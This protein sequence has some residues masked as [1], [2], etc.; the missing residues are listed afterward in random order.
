[1]RKHRLKECSVVVNLA[2]QRF[3]RLKYTGSSD[4]AI[5]WGVYEMFLTTLL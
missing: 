4:L 2:S 1:M 3:V 5:G